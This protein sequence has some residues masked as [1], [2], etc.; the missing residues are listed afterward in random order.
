MPTVIHR[1]KIIAVTAC[2]ALMIAMLGA[3]AAQ[4]A[5]AQTTTPT[6]N[7]QIAMKPAPAYPTASGT[8]QYQSQ[9]GQRELQVE[10]EHLRSLAGKYV[11]F[12]ANKTKFGAAKVSSLGIVQIDRNTELG[13]AVPSIV[14]GST[15]TARTGTGVLISYGQF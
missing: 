5:T 11:T 10:L 15:V 9:P 4:T 1:S 13:Q 7:W 3:F 2:A 6:V 12:Y 8:A 14:H